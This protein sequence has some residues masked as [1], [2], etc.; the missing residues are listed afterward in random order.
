MIITLLCLSLTA[1][2]NVNVGRYDSVHLM[3]APGKVTIDGDLA[4]W[5]KS[6]EFYTYRF[7]DQRDKYNLRGYMMY[8]A[9]HLYI[10]AHIGDRSPMMNMYNPD[11]EATVAWMGDCL[12]V[13][14][15]A[16]RA[17]GWPV[18]EGNTKS[19][20]LAHLTMW[21]YTL[22]AQPCLMVQ[23]G[24]D[25]HGQLINPPG[26][27][28][29]YKKDPDGNGYTL[30]YAI[31]WKLLHAEQDPPKAG[32]GL[33][34][35]WQMLWS[36]E[37]GR[38]YVADLSEIRNPSDSSLAYQSA[39]GWGKAI[40]EKTGNLPAGTVTARGEKHAA[41]PN[42]AF[43]PLTYHIAGKATKH[44]GMQIFDAQGRTV[45]W[46]LGDA[47]RTPGVHTELW[48]GLDN[49]NSPVP[50]GKYT[51][52]WCE[53][54]VTGKLLATAN[55]PG[56]PPYNSSDNRGS[57]AGDYGWATAVTANAQ[58]VFLAHL[59]GEASRALIKLTPDGRKL[60]GVDPTLDLGPHI[61]DMCNDGQ[62][63]FILYGDIYGDK[64]VTGGF[65]KLDCATGFSQAVGSTGKSFMVLTNPEANAGMGT[66]K[67]VSGIAVDA[68]T[69][70]VTSEQDGKIFC[71]DKATGKQIRVIDQLE[72][73]RGI[74]IGAHG[75]LYVVA[76]SEV[77]SM[78]ADGTERG[79][80]IRQLAEP[81]RLV[82]A[83]NGDLFITVQGI[84]HQVLHFDGNGKLLNA[85]GKRGGMVVPGPWVKEALLRPLA[86]CLTPN[87]NLW[88]TE[89]R[90]NP[91]RSSVWKQDGAFVAEYCGPVPYA[92]TCVMD[93][94]DPDHIYSEN[95]Q[96]K[97]DYHTGAASPS[98]V[99]YDD[100]KYGQLG[101]MQG[102]WEGRF[103]HVKDRTFLYRGQGNLYELVKDRFI[104][105]VLFSMEKP[106][107]TGNPYWPQHMVMGIDTNENGSIEPGEM[108]LCP[109]EGGA[110]WMAW[111]ADNLDIYCGDWNSIWRLPFEGFDSHGVPVYKMDHLVL[112][113]T[114][115]PE[116]LAKSPGAHLFPMPGNPDCWMTDADGNLY[117]LMNNGQERIK[118]DESH[119][120]K[121]HGLVKFSPD[122][123]VLWEYRNVVVGMGACWRTTISKPGEMLG[124]MRFT[125]QF[126]RYITVGT[127]FGQ[128]HILDAKTGLYITAFTPDTRSEPPLDGMVVLTE[129][130]NGCAL[131]APKLK[132]YL[133][134]GGDA[135]ARVWE[136]QGLDAV[137]FH[138]ITVTV[139]EEDHVKAVAASKVV[140]GL[141]NIDHPEKV[142]M[143]QS[144]PVT[145]DGDL[146][147]WKDAA[148]S[149]FKVDDKRQG[150]AAVVWQN[151][152][153]SVAFEVTDDSPMVNRGG[154]LNLLFKSGDALEFDISTADP[155]IA[156]TDESPI[157]GDKRI[158][159]SFVKD[160]QGNEKSVAMLYE[161][162]SDR[163][164][165]TPGTFSSP[166][167][168]VTYD[169]VGQLPA[170]VKIK[171]TATGY[172][173]E[174]QF[175]N[176]ALGC[177][178]FE[179]GQRLRADV[180]A[181][182]SDQG[183]AMVLA[184]TMWADDTPEVN[185]TNDV[186]TEARI[187]PKRWGW[188]VLR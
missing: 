158:L 18:R 136:V 38:K 22:K 29:A 16:D 74:A 123:H 173:L 46:M 128:Y 133:Y 17:L 114:R 124:T 176:D 184:K 179:V 48:N 151:N 167:S 129:N 178:A 81:R 122:M 110:G 135:N 188:I 23:N 61:I 134:C 51:V 89:E 42:T 37:Q 101:P 25:Y 58:N 1:W 73:P 152:A 155:D 164:N 59:C 177:T 162:K 39:G 92:S 118:R 159:I 49:D 80:L 69:V 125:N 168:T 70:Y 55:N 27:Q 144:F 8:D 7:E 60:W 142:L 13:R 108:Q 19:D 62:S 183:G 119:L 172:T 94:Q 76:G 31:S 161:P 33:A 148:W 175:T 75:R 182:F 99:S 100:G 163:A 147:E 116:R 85:I 64:C 79:T 120:D 50:P 154:N 14:F 160:A 24:M 93:P 131:Y 156:R 107:M 56:T 40:F 3:P 174:A 126:G 54:K 5:D 157:L 45:R 52:K 130:F 68:A 6:G 65:A 66:T 185:V 36:D 87:G 35:I 20:R 170:Q 139:K 43:F 104:P 82:V 137:K 9:E 28:G 30:E 41:K 106:A 2:A 145:V 47:E 146:G 140:Y 143:A 132:K 112:L 53:H 84:Y 44:V 138:E 26:Y 83:P 96:F 11:A 78:K 15:S 57:W 153:L 21:Y 72:K 95:T 77:I 127:Y 71:I 4:D 150:R 111:I 169:Y 113:L 67:N 186:P 105:R 90:M 63:L 12:Q 10:A 109:V 86:L 34:C 102:S 165:K 97:I 187:H 141:D 98:A 103:I 171:R 115:Q 88:V 91:K 180:G 32:D 117:V 166:V 121:G 181:L 149:S